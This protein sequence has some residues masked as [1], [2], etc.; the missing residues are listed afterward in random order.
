M[1][2]E[3]VRVKPIKHEK[4]LK[5]FVLFSTV[6]LLIIGILITLYILVD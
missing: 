1:N 3:N 2:E 6:V 5:I 4:A